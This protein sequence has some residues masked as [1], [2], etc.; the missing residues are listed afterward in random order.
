[1]VKCSEFGVIV[2]LS[3][4]SGARACWVRG[5]PFGLLSVRTTAASKR[6]G[7]CSAGVTSPGYD[8]PF[9]LGERFGRGAG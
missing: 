2:P 7:F 1:M 5:S 8:A 6:D 9:G 4:C 3:I